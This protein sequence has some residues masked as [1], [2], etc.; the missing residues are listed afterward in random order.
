[1]GRKNIVLGISA[2]FVSSPLGKLRNPS[3]SCDYS[4]G[5]QDLCDR[6]V[7]V[8]H[9]IRKQLHSRVPRPFNSSVTDSRPNPLAVVTPYRDST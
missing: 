7:I 6:C 8:S 5:G 3:P 2:S 4:H 9:H 1:M